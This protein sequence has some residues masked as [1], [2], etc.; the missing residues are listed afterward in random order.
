MWGPIQ[1]YILLFLESNS[2]PPK[3]WINQV[4]R[5]IFNYSLQ[6]YKWIYLWRFARLL[7]KFLEMQLVYGWYKFYMAIFDT[8]FYFS[9]VSAYGCGQHYQDRMMV[10]SCS[11]VGLFLDCKLLKGKVHG[12]ITSIMLVSVKHQLNV[13]WI[14]G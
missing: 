5:N 13:S 9:D 2:Y 7:G 10:I 4:Q 14:D 1:A 12:L 6:K 8:A 3:T 11:P